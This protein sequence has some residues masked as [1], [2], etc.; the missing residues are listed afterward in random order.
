MARGS[1][2]PIAS[3]SR[4][5]PTSAGISTFSSTRT[6]RS[7]TK[8][9]VPRSTGSPSGYRGRGRKLRGDGSAL[10]HANALAPLA[11]LTHGAAHDRPPP[12]QHPPHRRPARGPAL[13]PLVAERGGDA[14]ADE[15]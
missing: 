13:L 10:A 15:Q 7:C 4:G 2:W 5:R 8:A 9:R 11:S 1:L 12:R 14:H 6:A 3:K